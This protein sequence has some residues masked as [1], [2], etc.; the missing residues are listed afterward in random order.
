MPGDD[1]HKEAIMLIEEI[2]P[3]ALKAAEDKDLKNLRFRFSQ[4]FKRYYKTSPDAKVKGIGR[5][6]FLNRYVQLRVEMNRRGKAPA[7]PLE[8][9]GLVEER[10]TKR[11]IWNLDVPALSEILLAEGYA[12]IAGRF[13]KD[14]K[15][16]EDLQIILKAAVESRDPETEFKIQTMMMKELAGRPVFFNYQPAGPAETHI[17][18]F[19]LVLRPR[20][21]TKK[22]AGHPAA[23]AAG[24]TASVQPA[25]AA[26]IARQDQAMKDRQAEED[27]IRANCLTLEAKGP[28]QFNEA[29]YPNWDN[30]PRCQIC[31]GEKTL[32]GTC[33][34][35]QASW[36][37]QQEAVHGQPATL[38]TLKAAGTSMEPSTSDQYHRVPIQ[39]YG[40][41][42]VRTITFSG[43]KGIK[44]IEDM[45]HGKMLALL[46]DVDKFT[47]AEAVAWAKQ[48]KETKIKKDGLQAA[49]EGA[50]RAAELI[51]EAE[52]DLEKAE[53]AAFTAAD[54]EGPGDMGA[55]GGEAE[56][57]ED[58]APAGQAYQVLS[59]GARRVAFFK[60]GKD[61]EAYAGHLEGEGEE[62][63]LAL[64]NLPEGLEAVAKFDISKPETTAAYQR[65]PVLPPKP[66]A[67][68][69]TIVLSAP[70]GIKALEDIDSKKIMTYLFDAEKWTLAEAKAWVKD[71]QTKGAEKAAAQPAGKKRTRLFFKFM[72]VDSEKQIVGGVIYEPHT[73]DTQGDYTDPQ[74]IEKAMYRFMESYSKNQSRIKVMHKGKAYFFP[75]LES[76]QADEDTKKGTDTVKKG[77]WF[78]TVKVAD[79]AIWKMIKAKKLNGFSMGGQA[80]RAKT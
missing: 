49:Q 73:V 22:T 59:H 71:H 7:E 64:V 9:D 10:V 38:A 11:A 74:E 24:S 2:T 33:L 29:K 58:Q 75:I 66:G 78:L 37:A 27:L 23:K 46:F 80:A 13:I 14:P 55:I 35:T 21:M 44:G 63:G 17:P 72:K 48:Y 47:L 15:G 65:I 32:N 42:A 36:Q 51:I 69:R 19:D 76:F 60:A 56:P 43:E 57:E 12:S 53:A 30:K 45:T 5:A 34:G 28:H 62:P 79:E 52:G 50:D 18:I 3:S 8:L 68:I 1:R 25:L 6:D 4:L 54:S 70:Q 26:E 16:A 40:T 20:T 77:A 41:G 31:G 61:A 39:E 67:R